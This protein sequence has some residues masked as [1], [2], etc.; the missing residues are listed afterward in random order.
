MIALLLGC[1]TLLVVMA[2][3]GKFTRAQVDGIRQMGIWTA[4]IGGLLLAALLFLT[5][6]SGVALAAL[7]LLGPLLWSWILEGRPMSRT[8][9]PQPPPRAGAMTRAEAFEVL[10]LPPGASSEGIQAAYLRLMRAAH[11]DQGG[12]DW[13]A[14]RINQ[15]RDVL[16]P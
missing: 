4:A 3:L 16:L 2:A 10:G 5:G 12:S 1:A 7:A 15:A 13:L 6:R 11:P 8:A 9:R 14:A